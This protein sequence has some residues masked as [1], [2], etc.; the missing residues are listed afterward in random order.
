ML[1]LPS[2][3]NLEYFYGLHPWMHCVPVSNVHDLENIVDN[4]Q[5]QIDL[6]YITS[7]G[8]PFCTTFFLIR[9]GPLERRRTPLA[10]RHRRVSVIVDVCEAVICPRHALAREI[11]IPSG[12]SFDW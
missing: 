2:P 1:K 4:Y 8:N 3:N 12:Q 11:S 5:N 7:E 9:H 6:I 10:L